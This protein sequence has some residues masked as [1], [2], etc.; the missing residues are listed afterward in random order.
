MNEFY[1]NQ[2]YPGDSPMSGG[3]GVEGIFSKKIVP[4]W[5]FGSKND[6]RQPAV[7]KIPG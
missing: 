6:N 2:R 5:H 1:T 7:D 4:R 3:F